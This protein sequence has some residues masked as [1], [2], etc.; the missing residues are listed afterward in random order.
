MQGFGGPVWRYTILGS[1]L[2]IGAYN[3]AP[4]PTNDVYLTRWIAMY[5]AP[6]SLWLELNAKRTALAEDNSETNLLLSDAKK[7]RVHRFRYPQ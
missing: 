7:P 1:L 5:T 4:E 6:R 3:Y 2:A